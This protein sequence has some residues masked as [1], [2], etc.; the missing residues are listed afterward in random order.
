[1]MARLRVLARPY[2]EGRPL[3]NQ[4]LGRGGKDRSLRRCGCPVGCMR[5]VSKM[6]HAMPGTIQ[7]AKGNAQ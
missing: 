3:R 1:M 5:L 6:R 4:R 7:M 2:F